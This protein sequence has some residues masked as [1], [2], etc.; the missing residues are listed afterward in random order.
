MGIPRHMDSRDRLSDDERK[1]LA[2]LVNRNA[3]L[4]IELMGCSRETIRALTDPLGRVR[5]QTVE[6]A[7]EKL[8]RIDL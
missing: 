6:R 4:T 3:A 8:T 7:R 1:K 5:R 2:Q